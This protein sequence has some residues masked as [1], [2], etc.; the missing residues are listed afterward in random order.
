MPAPS[1]PLVCSHH[2]NI[3]AHSENCQDYVTADRSANADCQSVSPPTF[4]GTAVLP[5]WYVPLL[6]P[7]VLK[8]HYLLWCL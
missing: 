1:W 6:Y 2:I 8:H 7:P 5:V 3:H 4:V